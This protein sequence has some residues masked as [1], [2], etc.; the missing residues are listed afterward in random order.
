[1][2]GSSSRAKTASYAFGLKGQRNPEHGNPGA[3]VCYDRT[4]PHNPRA[5]KNVLAFFVMVVIGVAA[6]S[7]LLVADAIDGEM[8]RRSVVA[9]RR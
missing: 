2:G 4:S 7:C 5:M 9:A 6:G 3:H 1:M 8:K